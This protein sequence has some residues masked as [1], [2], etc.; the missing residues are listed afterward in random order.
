VT[1]LA[2]TWKTLAQLAP[3]RVA[4]GLGAWWEPIASRAGLHTES[5]LTA[6][7][8]V[9][10]VLREMFAGRTATCEGRYVQVHQVRFDGDEDEGGAAYDVPI[11]CAAVGP[12]MLELADGVL[13]DFFMPVGHT[14]RSAVV[15]GGA[16]VAAGRPA[17]A[18]PQLIACRV[19]DADPDGAARACRA[20]LTRYLAQQPHIG[21]HCG[22]EPELVDRVRGELGWPATRQQVDDAARLVP[23]HLVRDLTAC[24]TTTDVLDRIHEYVDAGCSE[25]VMAPFGPGSEHTLQAVARSITRRVA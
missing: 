24:G 23:L 19:D 8:E 13:L 25:V 22:L 12:R 5:P 4:L 11:Y 21:Q 6:M 17:P 16:A 10:E 18:L 3:G 2:M 7:R 15:V 14:R 9:V 20:V 1:L